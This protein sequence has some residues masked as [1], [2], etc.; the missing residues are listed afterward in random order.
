MRVAPV[1]KDTPMR[2]CHRLLLLVVLAGCWGIHRTVADPFPLPLAE[3]RRGGLLY[4]PDVARTGLERSHKKHDHGLVFESRGV[5]SPILMDAFDRYKHILSTPALHLAY[6][7]EVSAP[8]AL[9]DEGNQV[10]RVLCDV[11][12]ADQTLDLYTD[13]TYS[14]RI[15]SPDVT[16]EA[17]TVFG[18]LRALETLAQS[19]HVL[20]VDDDR[21]DGHRRSSR[22]LLVLNETALYDGPRFPHRGVLIDT[23]EHFFPLDVIK[24][25][26]DAMS[27]VKLNV[28]HWRMTG[29]ASW[30]YV[31]GSLPELSAAGAFS[32]GRQYHA[33]SID[34]L[35]QYAKHRGVR[36][37]VELN[38]P[39]HIGSIGKS[40][41]ECV[42]ACEDDHHSGPIIN[43]AT[44]ATY[45]MLWKVA[46]DLGRVFGDRAMHFGGDTIDRIA[47]WG[48]SPAVMGTF[49]DIHAALFSHTRRMMA[50]AA[51]MG[52]VPIVYDGL[53]EAVHTHRERG[54]QG[55]LPPETVVHVLGPDGSRWKT[56]IDSATKSG[57]RV[58]LSSPWHVD[59]T[60]AHESWS[61]W[62]TTEPTRALG[63]RASLEQEELVLGGEV[64]VR[65][66]LIDATNTLSRTWPLA[67]TAAERLW[68]QDTALVD[69]ADAGQRLFRLRCRMV[70]RGIPAAPI[71]RGW[72]ACPFIEEEDEKNAI[73]VS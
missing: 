63:K 42:V 36:V 15:S 34:E 32:P 3:E 29:D 41:P 55:V 13:E 23:S 57:K 50:F 46:R 25:H 54:G 26:I 19:T 40:H 38:S 51:A 65:S 58:V 5:S 9:P 17:Q 10:K 68:S 62:W 72:G 27:M 49:H 11:Q 33:G 52:K 28:L 67:A 20:K 31:V 8:E 61:E 24:N 71:S 12:N 39:A 45:D 69:V 73:F 1:R 16:I 48:S 22:T 37:V 35:V 14:I 64:V 4:F 60:V 56:T 53:W 44:N 30:P 21:A 66:R 2:T 18:A 47:C 43:P 6:E 59:D 7:W 70:A